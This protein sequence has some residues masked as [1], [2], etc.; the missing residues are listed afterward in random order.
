M[1]ISDVKTILLTGPCTDDPFLS[2][3]RARRSAAF[4][5]ISTDCGLTGLGETYAGYFLPEVV[6]DIVDFF[7]PILLGCE[8]DNIDVLWNRMYR[9]GNFWCRNGLGLQVLTGIDAALWDLKGKRYDLPVY[10]LLGGLKHESL[11]CYATGGPA[12]YPIDKLFRK[13]EYY[14]ALGF[15]A[16]KVAAGEFYSDEGLG[17][18]ISSAV[19]HKAAE[20]EAGKLEAIQSRFG[21]DV[22]MMLDGHMG[23][24]PDMDSVWNVDAA[25][26]VMKACEGYN[27]GFFEEPL[28]YNDMDGYTELCRS[29]SIPIAGGECL[30]GA[31]EWKIYIDRGCFD[32]GQ[33]DA[34]FVGG[35]GQ[36][37]K[38]A[39]L[40]DGTNRRL[41]THSWAAGGGFMQN[42]HAAFACSNTAILEIAP[43]F[44][45]LHTEIIGDGWKMVDGRVF[46]PE[47]PGLGITLS[48][49]T[50]E[51][52]PFVP[53]SGEFNTVPGK[54]LTD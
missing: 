36:F 44:G 27:I 34:S 22:T 45:P 32:I 17:R 15:K 47:A 52:F 28:H 53:G 42:L 40:L 48:E 4:I 14:M 54:I 16:V 51:R 18:F 10:Q 37:L 9:C 13:I 50:K 31:P 46:P 19:P 3:S 6:P 7:K 30:A 23:N 41:A 2:E 20:I 8:V 5:E 38:I 49:A 43:G 24:Y 11:P 12:N 33:P 26:A 39:Q 21:G 29:T 25:K 1:K 35:F